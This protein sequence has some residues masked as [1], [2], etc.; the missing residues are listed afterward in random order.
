MIKHI[1][2]WFAWILA[3]GF[4]VDQMEDIILV[5]G[6]DHTRSWA[7]VAFLGGQADARVSFGVEVTHS[8]ISWKFSPER[9]IGATWNQGPTGEV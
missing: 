8:K 6:T 3:K 5:T 2:Q 4:G 7:N 1:D 9:K